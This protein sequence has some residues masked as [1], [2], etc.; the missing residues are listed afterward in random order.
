MAC[1]KITTK[2][3]SFLKCPFCK[4]LMKKPK[5]LNCF[6]SFCESC[7]EKQDKVDQDGHSGIYCPVC[8]AFTAQTNIDSNCFLHE[9]LDVLEQQ[10]SEQICLGEAKQNDQYIHKGLMFPSVFVP[11][12]LT[13]AYH[14]SGR[15]TR[16]S[17]VNKSVWCPIPTQHCIDVIPTS[18]EGRRTISSKFRSL[19]PRS[20]QHA[21]TGHILLA[22][23]MGICSMLDDG[24]MTIVSSQIALGKFSDI[25]TSGNT[26]VALRYDTS[27]VYIFSFDRCQWKIKS[28]FQAGEQFNHPEYTILFDIDNQCIY[29]TDCSSVNKYNLNG[30]IIRKFDGFSWPFLSY[31]K[32]AILVADTGN[33][34]FK[35]IT[36][37]SYEILPQCTQHCSYSVSVINE[38]IWIGHSDFRLGKYYKV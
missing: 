31:V 13:N 24:T 19:F 38:D 26:A 18:G 35:C 3:E 8:N 25:S 9:L 15:C 32:G 23:D 34:L 1:S 37:D 14:L 7:I 22:S 16:I 6:H 10:K 12:L 36:G 33:K 2:L 29:I 27:E 20:V 4:D 28:I 21:D 11:M 5:M 17:L 30:D